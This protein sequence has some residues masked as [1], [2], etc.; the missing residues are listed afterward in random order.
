[1]GLAVRL[2]VAA[3][4]CSGAGNICLSSYEQR[5]ECFKSDP[6]NFVLLSGLSKNIFQL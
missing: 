1:M 6:P 5:K 3:G 2:S 4:W